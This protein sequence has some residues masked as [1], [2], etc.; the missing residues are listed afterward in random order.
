MLRV[1]QQLARQVLTTITRINTR[2]AAQNI[3][4]VMRRIFI[5][6]IMLG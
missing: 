1:S 4:F 6:F 3:A 2:V 5:V